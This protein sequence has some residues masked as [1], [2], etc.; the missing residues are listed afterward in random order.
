M[1]SK[2][3]VA[4]I[5]GGIL[6]LAHAYALMRRG[7]T[8]T[9]F[10]HSLRASGAS[11]RNFGMIWPVGQPPGE[12][13]RMA[14]R[15]RAIWLEVLAEAQ[16]PFLDTGSLH[17]AYRDDEA[18]V[19]REFADI[20]LAAGYACQW[21]EPASVLQRSNALKPEGLKG[22]I[23]STTEL[24]VDPRQVIPAIAQYIRSMGVEIHFGTP[25]SR[26]ELPV[27]EAG[28]RK[29]NFDAAVVCSGDDFETLYPET[30]ATSG[31]TRCKLQMMRTSPQPQG[32]QLGPALAAGLTLRF[33]KS[34]QICSTLSALRSRI[35][36]EQPEY[37]RW[38]IHIL[39][40]QTADGAITL[41][42]SHEYGLPVDIFDRQEIDDLILKEAATFLQLPDPRIAQ[43]WHGVYSLHPNQPFFSAE[44][45]P[46][47]RIVTAPGGS[48]MTLSFG[49][50]ERTASGF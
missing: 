44:P 31:L 47:V 32:W 24:T 33:Y 14:M 16:L 35:A 12:M 10:E 7:Y 6:G 26:I 23:I 17:V 2:P 40:S 13:H 42:D 45:A 4:V 46:G 39:V 37:D 27:V 48:G 49:L 25:V 22:G 36:M 29:W 28:G 20:G 21:L 5:G 19:L 43:R 9:L 41:G 34:F 15:S 38:G 1:D 11:I 50:A 8:V 18:E 30:F 3:R